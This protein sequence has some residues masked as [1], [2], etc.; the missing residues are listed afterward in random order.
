M[1]VLSTSPLEKW[2]SPLVNG[3]LLPVVLLLQLVYFKSRHFLPVQEHLCS[4]P[5]SAYLTSSCHNSLFLP[6]V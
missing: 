3:P 6:K 5:T 4:P 2:P 1:S